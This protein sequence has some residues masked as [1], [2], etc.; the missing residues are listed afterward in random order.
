MLTSLSSLTLCSGKGG[1]EAGQTRAAPG[2]VVLLGQ[3]GEGLSKALELERPSESARRA[4]FELN[5][6]S[7]RTEMESRGLGQYKLPGEHSIVPETPAL[8]DR[9]GLCKGSDTCFSVFPSSSTGFESRGL[10]SA[11]RA[12]APP[13]SPDAPHHP[14]RIASPGE[15][16]SNGSRGS[17]GRWRTIPATRSS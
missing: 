14:G 17:I 12:S 3:M 6:S 15:R 10:L 2:R 1:E 4:L 5:A 11:R 7:V 16:G 8:A 9:F 13:P